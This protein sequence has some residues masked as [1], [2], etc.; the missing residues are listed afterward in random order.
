MSSLHLSFYFLIQN[1]L[2]KLYNL[3]TCARTSSVLHRQ[4]SSQQRQQTAILEQ[5]H[6]QLNIQEFTTKLQH[7][8]AAFCSVQ[9][10]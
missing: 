10:L 6:F 8:V 7:E 3:P 5:C 1:M 9:K 4:P 2:L